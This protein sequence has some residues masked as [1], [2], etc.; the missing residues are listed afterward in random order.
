MHYKYKIAMKYFIFIKIFQFFTLLLLIN[1]SYS[2]LS[3]NFPYS[4]TLANGNIFVI[5]Q[6]GISICDYHLNEI[7]ENVTSF[8]G[9][10]EIKTESSL[11]KVTT[12][13]EYG[14][15]ISLINDKI[16]FFDE[17]GTL[18]YNEINSIL[19]TGETSDYYTLV[20][21]KKETNSYHYVIGYIYNKLLYLLNYKYIFSTKTNT[22]LPSIRGQVHDTPRYDNINA[23]TYYFQNKVLSCQY[24]TYIG[25]Y[26]TMNILVCFFLVSSSGNY[27]ITL[28]YFSVE[29]N[30][31]GCQIK[32]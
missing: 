27:Y 16:Y 22:K 18:I 21:I 6:K 13:F 32:S 1:I 12:A 23:G 4:L 31:T 14:Y 19:G 8:S 2:Y 29:E 10:E 26:Q 3:F 9:D 30:I 15:I 20:P 5:H 17:N 7:I 28:D 25:S 11:S 24:M